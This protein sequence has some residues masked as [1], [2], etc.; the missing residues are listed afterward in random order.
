M[1][2]QAYFPSPHLLCYCLTLQKPLW[3]SGHLSSLP[4]PFCST[5]QKPLRLSSLL[6]FFPGHSPG[7]CLLFFLAVKS[8][9]LVTLCLSF[10]FPTACCTTSRCDTHWL[11]HLISPCAVPPTVYPSLFGL[12]S[13]PRVLRRKPSVSHGDVKSQ[14]SQANAHTPPQPCDQTF[15]TNCM[16]AKK[17]SLARKH[18]HTQLLSLK[19]EKPDIFIF[20]VTDMFKLICLLS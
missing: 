16:S 1:L 15:T 12:F 11:A 8:Q 3:S 20:G 14:L 19:A 6:I 4:L 5:C 10:T 7:V 17:Y 13:F 9:F 2:T 18:K